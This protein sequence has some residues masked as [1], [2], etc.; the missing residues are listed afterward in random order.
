MSE[1]KSQEQIERLT[2]DF[3]KTINA[4][5]RQI[6]KIFEIKIPE[7]YS[8]IFGRKNIVITFDSKSAY[9]STAE[10]VTFGNELLLKIINLCQT[11]GPI[12]TAKA[13]NSNENTNEF[14][15]RF[16]FNISYQGISR[17]SKL[18]FIDLDIKSSELIQTDDE[19]LFNTEINLEKINFELMPS[20]YIKST[21]LIRQ[22]FKEKEE[23]MKISTFEK[24]QTEIK[25]NEE[26]YEEMI[27]EEE[28][29]IK[30]IEKLG[31][32][33]KEKHK[34]FDEQ[35]EKIQTIR[36]EK[37]EMKHTISAK[38]RLV[39]SYDLISIVIFAY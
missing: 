9:N 17:I 22:K 31:I 18:S 8:H 12:I 3:F 25:K 39:F 35:M 15:I 21:K 29:N 23:E 1:L 37:E 19:L 13:K 14:G 27:T 34:L 24:Q 6:N 16:Y 36:K 33:E 11:K 32:A 2:I 10:L 20:L 7:S 26:K 38:F 5:I 28:E 30:E 4:D